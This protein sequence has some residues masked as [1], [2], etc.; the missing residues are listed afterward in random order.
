MS[1][2]LAC[3]FCRELY[4]LGERE[5][6]PQ[7]DLP[8]RALHRLPKPQPELE[9]EAAQW[10]AGDWQDRQR[11]PW[12]LGAGKGLLLGASCAGLACFA[13]APWVHITAP[14]T[15]GRSGLDLAQGPLGW[16]WGGAVAWAT[17]LVLVLSRRTLRQM[18]GVRA[19]LFVFSCMT[20]CEVGLLL[21]VPPSASSRVRFEYSWAWGL[22]ASAS[23]SALSALACL[24]FGR[25]HRKPA[26]RA[27]APRG[28]PVELSARPARRG[29]ESGETIH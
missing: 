11:P 3:P 25:E 1:R 13:L 2:L 4:E 29:T 21:S 5:V 23:I 15:A 22:Y 17:S 6:C 26:G 18:Q 7:C 19:I 24:R 20:L 16:L 8:L 14:Y 12:D 10:E 28:A 27:A 9:A